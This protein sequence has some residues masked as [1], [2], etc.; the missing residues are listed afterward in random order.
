MKYNFDEQINR[1]GSNCVKWDLMS[2]VYG[3]S[4]N[5]D[6]LALW[7]A[8]M[9]FA[10]PE[11]IRHAV[12]KRLE[13]PVLGY[14]YPGD[15]FFA[16]AVDWIKRRYNWQI[17]KDWISF[18]PG[19]VPA[20]NLAIL[21]ASEPGDSIVSLTPVYTPF[22]VVAENNDRK[23]LACDLDLDENLHAEIN[24]EKLESMLDE[25][26]KILMLCSPHNPCGRV[27]TKEELSKLGEIA[28]RHDLLILA[29]EIHADFIYSGHE[30]HSIAA[31]DE[32]FSERSI[33]CYAPSKTFN[34]AGLSASVIVIPNAELKEKFDTYKQ[35]LRYGGN[36]FAYPALVAAWS[37]A[38]DWLDELIQYL[39]DNRDYLYAELSQDKYLI[40]PNKPEGTYLLWLDCRELMQSKALADDA[41]LCE[42]FVKEGGLALN[43]G[44]A[45]GEAASGF[46]R[47]NYACPRAT[48]KEA[49]LRLEK[50]AAR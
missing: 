4:A 15:E 18:S 45:Y 28:V 30:H 31:L 47:L 16:T 38:E 29:D 27:W 9:D 19:V 1:Y 44:L 41:A 21:A 13:H 2:K 25:T 14:S 33:T 50:I 42:Y 36:L 6:A 22:R 5:E 49:V 34:M 20:L 39:E 48:L 7:V 3:E 17:E 43:R 46:M 11:V 37:E 12:A 23:F 32:R 26:C 35:K 24:F 10:T 8:D 40:K